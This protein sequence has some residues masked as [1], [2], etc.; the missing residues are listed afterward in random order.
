MEGGRGGEREKK[1]KRNFH[2]LNYFCGPGIEHN[3]YW[4]ANAHCVFCK[5]GD[6]TINL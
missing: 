2:L 1:K 5:A 6:A 3:S 4:L